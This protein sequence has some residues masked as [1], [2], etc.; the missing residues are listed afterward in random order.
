MATLIVRMLATG[1]EVIRWQMDPQDRYDY[2]EQ[3][4]PGMHLTLGATR[5]RVHS[6]AWCRPANE[7]ILGV[8]HIGPALITEQIVLE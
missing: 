7:L 8:S 6:L 1:M 5:Y 2:Y 4:A 3:Y